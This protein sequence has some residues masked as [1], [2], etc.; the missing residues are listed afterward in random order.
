MKWFIVTLSSMTFITMS[1]KELDRF[2]VI[3]KVIGNHINGTEAAGVLRVSTRHVRRLKAKV[4]QFGAKGLLHGNRG[5]ESHNSIDHDEKQKIIGLLHERYADF[6]P[7][8]ANEKLRE[9]HGIV[10]DSKTIRQIMIDEGLWKPR[11]QKKTSIHRGWR[12]RR[13]CYGDMIQ[14]DGSYDHWFED[15]QGTSELCLLAAIDDATGNLVSLMF[16]EHE[17]VFPVFRFWQKYLMNNGKP[18]SIYLD[19]FSTYNVNHKLAKE[20]SDTLTQF[21]RAAQTL[22]IEL[23]KANS[24][25]AKG[26]VERL[27]HTLQDRLMKEL[28]LQN[29]STVDEANL[30]LEKRFIPTFNARFAVLPK[31]TTNLHQPLTSKERKHC[32]EIFSRQTQ[33]TVLNDFTFSFHN[34]WVQLTKEQSV[35]ICKKDIV[36]VEEHLDNTMHLRLR[37]KDLRYILLPHRPE[38]AMKPMK[39]P[40]VI[41]A[42]KV[43]TPLPNHPWRHAMYTRVLPKPNALNKTPR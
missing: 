35:T 31:N 11:A 10:R 24:P 13:S 8:F 18:R 30:F 17:G 3:Q 34:Q 33:R 41:A 20:N 15:R 5:K 6:K 7:T 22:Q 9:H 28:R 23:I 2:H 39:L 12:E 32:P 16:A 38:K 26:R 29:I 4:K 14:F 21:E 25:Q 40:W 27:F 43:R 19:K 1:T 37:G 42:S 36:T